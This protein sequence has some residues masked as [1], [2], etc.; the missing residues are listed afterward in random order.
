MSEILTPTFRVL[1]EDLQEAGATP[2]TRFCATSMEVPL[3]EYGR[4][5][6]EAEQ[7]LGRRLAELLG[8]MVT[9]Y[10]ERTA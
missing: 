2:E 6:V 10:M 5:I 3:S 8:Q 9:E 4:T 7:K 1:I